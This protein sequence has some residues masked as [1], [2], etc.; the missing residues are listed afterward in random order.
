MRSAFAKLSRAT[1]HF[2]IFAS[3]LQEYRDSEAIRFVVRTRNDPL[4]SQQVIIETVARVNPAPPSERWGLMVG[5]VLTNLRGALDHALFGHILARHPGLTEAQQKKIQ[6]PVIDDQSK[7]S[8]QAATYVNPADPWAD[9]AVWAEIDAVQPF[10]SPVPHDHQLFLLHKLVNLDK[11]R[12]IHVVAHRAA[13]TLDRSYMTLTE[14]PNGGQPLVDGAV[15]AKKTVPRPLPGMG[16][17]TAEGQGGT[18]YHEVLVVPGYTH[19]QLDALETMRALVAA[20]GGFLD[21]LKV[22]GC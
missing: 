1:E 15:L 16:T 6:F 17:V 10:H 5:D 21:T 7:W 12:G 20:T 8:A 13:A 14:L 18:A 2:D 11:H 22:A 3:S 9:Q 19:I 4:N